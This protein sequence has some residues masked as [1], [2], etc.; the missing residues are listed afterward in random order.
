MNPY[1][2]AKVLNALKVYGH[3]SQGLQMQQ[4]TSGTPLPPLD[5]DLCSQKATR[6]LIKTTICLL[7]RK[8]RSEMWQ[9]QNH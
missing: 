4:W 9:S 7:P 3:G 6:I 1:K 8:Y 5:I 2:C